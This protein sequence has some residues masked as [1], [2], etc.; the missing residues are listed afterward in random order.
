MHVE[1]FATNPIIRPHM[2]SRMGD[3]INGPSLIKVPDW[4]SNPLGR[5]YL[6]FG[7]HKGQYIR[8]AYADDL[9]GPWTMYEPGTLR[10][11][12]TPCINHIA[13][14]DIH[15]DHEQQEIRM[16]YHGPMPQTG[17]TIQDH[18][19]ILGKQ[20]SLV[21]LSKDGINFESGQEI[22]G[23]SYFRVWTWD[24]WYYALG[25]PGMFFRSRDGLSSFEMGPV[26][27]NE[28]M[29]HTAVLRQEHTLYIFYSNA[30]DCPEHILCTTLDLRGDWQNWQ[31]NEPVSVLKPELDYEGV[32]LP[33]Q[34]SERG[35]APEPVNQLRDPGIFVEGE[36][37]YLIYSVSG[38]QG[39]AMGR[40]EGLASS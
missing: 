11:D 29:R 16:Y 13:S 30:H 5:Y 26:L 34:P 24:D 22:F 4:L 33:L 37:V 21:A 39:L 9:T 12:Q 23:P 10:L 27:F 17:D 40:L 19:P 7:H 14:P 28:D 8:L 35:W 20:R 15:I 38:E 3:N 36:N 25:M 2:D 6:Y 1:R 31:P 32:N 18:F